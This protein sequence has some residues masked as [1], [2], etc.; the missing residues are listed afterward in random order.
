[1]IDIFFFKNGFFKK[2][3]QA[4]FFF[5]TKGL[6]STSVTLLNLKEACVVLQ[7]ICFVSAQRPTT[8]TSHWIILGN[9]HK[10][11][12]LARLLLFKLRRAEGAVC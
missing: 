10:L 6:I 12:A 3:A 4:T 5:S 1:M 9:V 11:C 2:E 7:W 8:E